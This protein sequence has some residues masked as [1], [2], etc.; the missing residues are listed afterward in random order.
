MQNRRKS[1]AIARFS[2]MDEFNTFC[3]GVR[4]NG[5]GNVHVIGMVRIPYNKRPKRGGGRAV[6]HRAMN[7]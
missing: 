4:V 3:L 6:P 5:I 2:V 7:P 1:I